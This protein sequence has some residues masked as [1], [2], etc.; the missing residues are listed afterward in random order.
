[1]AYGTDMAPPILSKKAIVFSPAGSDGHGGGRHSV[2][3]VHQLQS[4]AHDG[5]ATSRRS[6]RYVRGR[7]NNQPLSPH[8]PHRIMATPELVSL[9]QPRNLFTLPEPA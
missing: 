1:M 7:T 4:I 5:L 9:R 3:A 2:A 8:P 6:F